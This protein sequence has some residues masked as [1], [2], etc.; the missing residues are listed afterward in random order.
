MHVAALDL[1]RELDLLR[2]GEQRVPAGLAEEELQ[3]VRR[4]LDGAAATAG[5][6][7]PLLLGL[8]DDELDPSAV[9]LLVHGF[10]LE[11]LELERLEDLVQVDLPHLPVRFGGFEQRR[12]LLVHEDRIDLDRQRCSPW[13]VCCRVLPGFP[14]LHTTQT[15]AASRNQGPRATER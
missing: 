3:R 14:R 7:E 13:S 2:R 15:R 8:L 9:E 10:E 1:L 12:K 6:G 11:R 5:V 4:R